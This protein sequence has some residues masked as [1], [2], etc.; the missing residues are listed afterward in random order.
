MLVN[1]REILAWAV[2]RRCAVASFNTYDLELTRALIAAAEA[3]QAP[4]FLAAGAGALEFAGFTLLS[5]VVLAAAEEATVP[6][7]VH[8][9][10]AT[11]PALVERAV[12]AGFTSVMVDGSALP[13][14]GNVAHLQ[15]AR[16][17]VGPWAL[18]GELGGVG[19]SEDRAGSQHSEVPMTDPDEAAAFAE[20]TGIDSLAV[21][22]GN[23]HGVY[24][25]EP[26]LDLDRLAAIEA[27]S[28]VP[29]V[30]HGASG[31]PD[32]LI[33][34]CIERGV[35]KIN[36]N[37]ELRRA[38]FEQLA[39]GLALD[40]GRYDLPAVFGGAMESVTGTA[41]SFIRLFRDGASGG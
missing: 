4:I 21:A 8:L 3:E 1:G 38:W 20:H 2:A 31:I 23:A 41:R 9:D 18:E 34:A 12:A 37:T 36:V 35:R 28:P 33:A 11:D 22:I 14:A 5:A 17:A 25:G 39:A 40:G 32:G 6:V 27:V 15:A 10:H 30:L 19:G 16:T 26:R 13:F 29:L 24:K 7:A